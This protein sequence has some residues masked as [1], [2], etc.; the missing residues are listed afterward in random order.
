MRTGVGL[1]GCGTVGSA[2]AEMLLTEKKLL[3]QR[4]GQNLELKGI[5]VRDRSRRR[6][7][8]IPRTLFTIK[9]AD[10]IGDPSVGVVVE[11]LGGLEPAR[12]LALAALR[13]GKHLVTANKHLLAV[14]GVEIFAAAA[15]AQRAVCFEASCGG[16]IPIV[17]ALTRGLVANDIQR[18]SGIVNGTC[19]YILTEMSTAGRTYADALAGAQAGGYAESD[20]TLDVNGTDSA[21]KL[22]ILAALAFGAQISFARIDISGIDKLQDQDL[23]YGKEL[24]YVCKLLAIAEKSDHGIS[25]RVHPAFLDKKHLLANVNG[26]FN[27][28]SVSGHASGQTIYYGRGAGPRPTASAVLAD[29]VEASMGTAALVF[30][31]L[32]LLTHRKAIKVVPIRDIRS[33]NYLR[34]TALDVP[35]VMHRITGILGRGQ[36]SIAAVVQHESRAGQYVPLVVITHEARDGA[37]SDAVRQ[38]DRLQYIRG[39][40]MRIRISE[41]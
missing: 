23:G 37:V 9:A 26:P 20:P 8:H 40:T 10:I 32:P 25:L 41:P 39:Q 15:Q 21:H 1:L 24:G 18:V 11:L 7:A 16:A 12:T 30:A 14:H 33:R 19:N 22:A 4:S 17:M 28:I 36:I 38:I 13:A 27:A 29:I 3:Q 6:S 31:N 35:G 5:L 2:V 34:M